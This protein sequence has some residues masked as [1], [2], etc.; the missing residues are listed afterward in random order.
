MRNRW[1]VIA[2]STLLGLIAPAA[3]ADD[4][5]YPHMGAYGTSWVSTPAFDRVAREG[6]LFNRAY[7]PNAIQVPAEAEVTFKV[8][9]VDVIHGFMIPNT[10]VNAM[11]IPGHV[12]EVTYEFDEPG[13]H[14]VVCHEFCGIGH[15]TMFMTVEVTG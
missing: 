9:S 13:E 10:P 15:H 14:N 3:I 2:L 5:S 1:A 11:L 8:T 7:T 4:I 12:T 6:V